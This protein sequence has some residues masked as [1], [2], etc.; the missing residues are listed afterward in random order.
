MKTQCAI[1]SFHLEQYISSVKFNRI[2]SIIAISCS[3]RKAKTILMFN[4]II[5]YLK[6]LDRIIK[7]QI[8]LILKDTL[9]SFIF[10]LFLVVSVKIIHD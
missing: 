10:L 4:N 8:T 3:Q 7:I 6:R 2:S 1:S 9:Q 5:K